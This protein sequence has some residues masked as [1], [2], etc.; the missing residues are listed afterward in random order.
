MRIKLVVF[1][2]LWLL[3]VAQWYPQTSCCRREAQTLDCSNCGL[4][5]VPWLPGS[6]TKLLLNKN[7]LSTI[8]QGVFSG[9][10]N[11][12]VLDL[13]GNNLTSIPTLPRKIRILRLNGNPITSIPDKIIFTLPALTDLEIANIDA[14]EYSKDSFQ[15]LSSLQS[16]EMSYSIFS[17]LPEQLFSPLTSLTT[18][19]LGRIYNESG[20]LITKALTSVSKTLTYLQL[21]VPERYIFSTEYSRFQ[22]LKSLVLTDT[23]LEKYCNFTYLSNE[24]FKV[25]ASIPLKLLEISKC[26][27]SAISSGS[28]QWFSSLTSLTIND[29]GVICSF[30]NLYSPSNY[31]SLL[32][33]M[34]NIPSTNLLSLSTDCFL[35][36][37]DANVDL[38][39][40]PSFRSL[41]NLTLSS[42]YVYTSKF[43]NYL[44]RLEHLAVRGILPLALNQ[45]ESLNS[46]SI[47]YSYQDIEDRKV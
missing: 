40:S 23:S 9:V 18:L 29:I 13:S 41:S 3:S 7:E 35:E 27:V 20:I 43:L 28:L 34:R 32:E 45:T 39:D 24:T 6:I 44:P 21:S 14:L 11:L 8:D 10:P 1:C 47:G 36:V 46:L 5:S 17:T 38:F 42:G 22:N 37:T 25:F 2:S 19:K 31:S 33:S 4:T 26:E 16:L 30:V 12:E 15:G